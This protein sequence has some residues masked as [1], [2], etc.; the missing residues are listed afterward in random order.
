MDYKTL[1]GIEIHSELLT[2]S[3]AFCSCKNQFGSE[4]NTNCCPVCTG[5][6][7]TLP[8]LN[9]EVL[10]FA[11]MAGLATNCSIEKYTKMDRKNYFY[12][13]LTK[14]YQISQYDKPLCYE[15]YVEIED[16]DGQP[17]KI[18][19]IRIHMEE[20]TGKSIHD[21]SGESLI[22][23]NRAG[24]P[25]IEIVSYPDMNSP[26]EAYRYLENLK[27]ILLFTGVSDVKMEQGSLRCD[28]N[29]NVVREDGVKSK[30]V[31]LKNLNSFKSAL[32]AMEYEEARHIEL[33]EK[34]ENTLKETR[35]WDEQNQVTI[36]MRSKENVQD[37]R[38]FPEADI[39]D[40]TL[41]D[42][43]IENVR[44]SLPELP[45]QKR[46]RFMEQYGLTKDDAEVL[47]ADLEISSYFEK[48]ISL[49]KNPTLTANFFLSEFLRRLK[50]SEQAIGNEK[51]TSKQFAFLLDELSD[52]KINNNTAKKIFRK[53][54]EEGVDP[55]EYIEQEGLAQVQDEDF[56]VEIV[57]NVL[58]E[59]PQSIQDI[60]N[61]KDRA[62]GFLVGQVMKASKGK[63]NPQIVNELLKQEID[64]IIGILCSEH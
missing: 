32:K 23:Y 11:V 55:K 17:K 41:T 40:I 58:A 29:I 12:P 20:D 44:K 21:A 30:I 45:A 57:R 56:I 14:G 3:K 13:D 49:T 43:Y 34:G 39:V 50:D 7:G 59:N 54:F 4:V 51:F 33:L 26:L 10:H 35:R 52:K 27:E 63:A 37:Y 46:K 47:N 6:P 53:M 18:R 1:I 15:G 9:E 8:V 48:L 28:V 2:K 19:L 31:E 61:G 22:D 38:Y 42:E 60:K 25:L 62:F 5:M 16:K 24:V 36:S 64:S